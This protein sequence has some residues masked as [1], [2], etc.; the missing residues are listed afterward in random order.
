MTSAG[1]AQGSTARAFALSTLVKRTNAHATARAVSEW[2]AV[3]FA[4]QSAWQQQQLQHVALM[5]AI[6]NTV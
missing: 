6:D 5:Q 3:A 4:L 2:S 1:L